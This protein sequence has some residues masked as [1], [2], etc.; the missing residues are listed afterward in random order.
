MYTQE[1]ADN[2][3]LHVT[4]QPI[5]GHTGCGI[6]MEIT[7]IPEHRLGLYSEDG[8]VDKL[9][10]VVTDFGNSVVMTYSEMK[11]A[12]VPVRYETDI[13]GRFNRQQELLQSFK[14]KYL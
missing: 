14:E 1:K 7:D 2:F 9:Y 12:Y 10:T 3:S 13:L 11:S 8:S 6:I 4:V 5:A